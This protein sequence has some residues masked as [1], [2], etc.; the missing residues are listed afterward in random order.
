MKH[1]SIAITLALLELAGRAGPAQAAGGRAECIAPAKPGGG[2]DLT[3]QLVRDMLRLPLPQPAAE[4]DIK[5]MPGG[6][7]AVVFDR[8]VTQRWSDPRMFVAFSSGSLLNLAQGKFGPHDPQDVRWLAALGTEYGVVAVRK[9][10]RIRSLQELRKLLAANPAGAV[11][12]AGGAV[13]SQDWVKAAL[14]VKL[15]GADHRAM[16]FVSFEGGGQAIAALR[17]GHVE[18][19]CG[20]AAEARGAFVAGDLKLL[21]VLAPNRLGTVFKDVPTARELGMDLVWPTVRGLYMG[22]GVSDKDR[23][24]WASTL[25]RIMAT[26]VYARL[27]ESAALQ[28]FPMAGPELDAYVLHQ[29]QEMRALA[30]SLGLRVR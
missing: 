3:C 14:L 20:D 15:A 13:G 25:Q 18:V 6:I 16:R 8:A 5:Y 29:V 22:P 9:D 21:A 17:G 24:E 10:S 28:P 26:P 19:F 27:L 4:V 11:F 1:L 7:G 23:A 2:F 30:R 12:G